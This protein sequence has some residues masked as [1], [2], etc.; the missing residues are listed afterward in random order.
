MEHNK[1]TFLNH[2]NGFNEE[3]GVFLGYAGPFKARIKSSVDGKV[4]VLDIDDFWSV[5]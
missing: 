1:V 5:R 2:G 4:H 3:A